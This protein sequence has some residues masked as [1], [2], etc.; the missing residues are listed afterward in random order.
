MTANIKHYNELDLKTIREKAGLDFAHYTYR[1]GQCSCCY[2]PEDLPKRYWN[3]ESITI[4]SL[5]RIHPKN[6]DYSYI[7]FK[8]SD[9]GSGHVTS[10]D[11]IAPT[12]HP[13]DTVYVSYGFNDAEQKNTVITLLKEQLGDAYTVHVPEDDSECISITHN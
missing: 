6:E 8:N 10:K 2:G 9:N 5:D 12:S 4:D 3:P 1:K 7:L 13:C 11:A